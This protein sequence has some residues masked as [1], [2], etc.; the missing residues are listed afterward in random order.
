M[1]RRKFL[2]EYGAVLPRS[3]HFATRR[4]RVRRGR[5]N[6]VASVGMT[7]K[8]SK[9]ARFRKR[10]LQRRE[11]PKSGPGEPGPYKTEKG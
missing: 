4:A 10:P 5:K 7:E 3:L 9:N 11:K 2:V 8:K 6:R 1:E